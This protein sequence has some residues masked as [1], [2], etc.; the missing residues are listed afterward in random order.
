MKYA[1]GEQISPMR[2]S[3][4]TEEGFEVVLATNYLGHFLLTQLLLPA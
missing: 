1:Y 4:V 3:G 2:E